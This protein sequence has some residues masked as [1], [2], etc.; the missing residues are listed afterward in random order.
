MG[1]YGANKAIDPAVVQSILKVLRNISAQRESSLL[2][3]LPAHTSLIVQGFPKQQTIFNHHK[4][5][6][7]HGEYRRAPKQKLY[8]ELRPVIAPEPQLNNTT[9]AQMM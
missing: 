2:S 8:C 9:C 5:Q 3:W 4:A 6:G 1:S 7:P